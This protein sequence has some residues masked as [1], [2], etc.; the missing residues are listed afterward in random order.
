MK[1]MAKRYVG[2]VRKKKKLP[3]SEAD[4]SPK[5]IIKKRE[6]DSYWNTRLASY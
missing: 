3:K 4:L 6:F 2:R 5:E 1:K